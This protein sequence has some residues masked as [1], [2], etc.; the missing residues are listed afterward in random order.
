MVTA[1]PQREISIGHACIF[2]HARMFRC[3]VID[4]RPAT[5]TSRAS[6]SS[7]MKR[8]RNWLLIRRLRCASGC[9]QGLNWTDWT[10]FQVIRQAGTMRHPNLTSGDRQ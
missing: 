7:E 9:L 3:H 8:V 10:H 4:C 2:S 5:S 1:S 6:P